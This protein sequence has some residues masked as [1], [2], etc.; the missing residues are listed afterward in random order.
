MHFDAKDK[1]G[2]G[3]R[4]KGE[5]FAARFGGGVDIYLSSNIVFVFEGGYVLPTG[6]V[7]GLDYASFAVGFQYRF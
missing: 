6:D 2:L 5:G 1:L 3:V 4:E 7:D